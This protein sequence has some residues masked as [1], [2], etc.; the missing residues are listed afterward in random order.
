MEKFSY[1]DLKK[2]ECQNKGPK[3]TQ[4]LFPILKEIIQ[5]L[6]TNVF[7]QNPSQLNSWS[8]PFKAQKH[9][10]GKT[11][12]FYMSGNVHAYLPNLAQCDV[13]IFMKLHISLKEL[14]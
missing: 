5:L 10:F 9:I 2:H 11:S 1:N 12:G 6:I 13:S 7:L 4:S 14:N 8:I 3:P